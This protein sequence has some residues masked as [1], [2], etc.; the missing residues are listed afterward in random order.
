MVY[1]YNFLGLQHFAMAGKK[2]LKPGECASP[3]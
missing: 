1:D 3:G 2:K